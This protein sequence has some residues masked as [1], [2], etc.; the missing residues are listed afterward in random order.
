MT[1]VD[2]T[3]ALVDATISNSFVLSVDDANITDVA[4]VSGSTGAQTLISRNIPALAGEDVVITGG[5]PEGDDGGNE[6]T[7]IRA[8]VLVTN[9]GTCML[10]EM[11][12]STS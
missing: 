3:R 2:E 12:G 10:E 8:S 1:G 9:N 6:M 7:T 5:E 4:V 11:A